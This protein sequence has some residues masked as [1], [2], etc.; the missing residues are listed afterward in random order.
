MLPCMEVGLV[1]VFDLQPAAR[2]GFHDNGWSLSK[3]PQKS[4]AETRMVTK[5]L[6]IPLRCRAS[7]QG[8]QLMNFALTGICEGKPKFRRSLF[9]GAK[10]CRSVWLSKPLGVLVSL[11]P[12]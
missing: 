2:V 9:S 5:A 3:H 8:S 6:S 10:S 11:D 7:K 12:L 4:T 1:E